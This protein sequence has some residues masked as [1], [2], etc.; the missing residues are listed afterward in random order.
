MSRPGARGFSPGSTPGRALS[1]PGGLYQGQPKN[2]LKTMKAN[3]ETTKAKKAPAKKPT[4]TR[5]AEPSQAP[6]EQARVYPKSLSELAALLVPY[7]DPDRLGDK[8]TLQALAEG[9][10]SG[11]AGGAVIRAAM[12]A[13]DPAEV[14]R[15]LAKWSNGDLCGYTRENP[16]RLAAQ[17]VLYGIDSGA[18]GFMLRTAKDWER[19]GYEVKNK[20]RK[21]FVVTP[22][23]S[24]KD[25][26]K[27]AD[28]GAEMAEVTVKARKKHYAIYALHPGEDCE[29]I[30]VIKRR[31][32]RK[33]KVTAD[34]YRAAVMTPPAAPAPT[35]EPAT[36]PAP[37][38][39]KAAIKP[40]PAPAFAAAADLADLAQLA[41]AL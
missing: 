32:P 23:F 37:A 35:P 16:A 7:A 30:R 17:L 39:R 4:R 21:L 9:K 22:L 40:L 8:S 28:D 24:D 34:D 26:E 15:E 33:Q 6:S 1:L 29:Q 31:G 20:E 14:D 3:T 5:K 18:K 38:P 10:G 12:L 19:E 11:L 41:L 27:A 36:V 2:T 13:A 25:K